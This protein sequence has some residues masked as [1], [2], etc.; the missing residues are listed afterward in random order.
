MASL[1][2]WGL[3]MSA[4]DAV[5][6][7]RV[8]LPGADSFVLRG[9]YWNLTTRYPYNDIASDTDP[10]VTLP[11]GLH[12]GESFFGGPKYL[13]GVSWTQQ[14]IRPNLVWDI[15]YR[16]GGCCVDF[17]G[18][19][20]LN[21]YDNTQWFRFVAYADRTSR[22]TYSNGYIDLQP[23][24]AAGEF[25][26][27]GD[28]LPALRFNM[29]DA[30]G[31]TLVQMLFLG[32]PRPGE[33]SEYLR[34]RPENCDPDTTPE[35]GLCYIAS[36]DYYDLVHNYVWYMGQAV[37]QAQER[38]QVMHAGQ[39]AYLAAGEPHALKAMEDSSVLVTMLVR[40]E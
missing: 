27:D 10:S 16:L 1:L 26:V 3:T 32:V 36:Y 22:E 13:E 37:P 20:N 35:Y 18:G 11:L 31:E 15:D 12:I 29:T 39:M 6:G 25:L 7:V 38:S 23:D 9:E 14:A 5:R 8:D 4:A 17:I 34:D 21:D 28:E 30:N 19:D 24:N 33:L 40:R 2:V